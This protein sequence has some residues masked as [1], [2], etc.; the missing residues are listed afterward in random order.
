M[1]GKYPDYDSQLKLDKFEPD[2]SSKVQKCII[3]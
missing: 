1:I 2:W 3:I